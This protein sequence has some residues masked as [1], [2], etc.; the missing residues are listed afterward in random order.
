MEVDVYD[1]ITR[2]P[3]AWQPKSNAQLAAL[4]CPAELLKFGGAAGSM[5]STTILLDSLKYKDNK[6]YRAVLFRKTYPEIKF[7]IDR[8]HEIFPQMGAR[9]L[10]SP[11]EWRWPWGSSIEFKYLERDEDVHKH[12]G[13]EYQYIGFD[14]STHFKEFQIRY[15]LN[16]RMRSTDNIPL[17]MRL[18][19]NPGNIGG[20]YHKLI[21]QGKK[22]VHCIL[23][24]AEIKNAKPKWD[25]TSRLPGVIYEDAVW[26]SDGVPIQHTTCFIPGR[27][28]DHTMFGVGGGEYVKKLRGLSAAYCESLLEGCWEAFEGKYFDCYSIDSCTIQRE[29]LKDKEWWPY[30]V[31]IDYGFSHATAAYLFTMAPDG[32]VYVTDEYVVHRRK[33]VDVAKDLQKLWGNRNIKAWY[34]SPDSFDHDGTDDFSKAEMMSLDTGIYFDKAYNE[35]VS[36]AMMMYTM[37]A[38]HRLKLCL[39]NCGGLSNSLST[40]VHGEEKKSEDVFKNESEDEDDMY[41]A[42]R[43]GVASHINPTSRPEQEVVKE[44]FETKFDPDPTTAM[45]Q[46]QNYLANKQRIDAG[47]SYRSR[48][49]S[50]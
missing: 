32:T 4:A 17:R 38:E 3:P 49:R 39:P 12:Q 6:H 33:A 25:A 41:D 5:K 31:G 43:Y 47:A 26:P 50:R 24:E 29:E 15:L 46:Y 8:S 9:F 19:T 44:M 37:L 21:F 14:E 20:S 36:G 2:L 18:A 35:R 1:F 11:K 48:A 40:R 22:C 34:L 30:W 45:I 42:A 27:V 7:L 10:S 28:Q 16:S 23:K 13:Q